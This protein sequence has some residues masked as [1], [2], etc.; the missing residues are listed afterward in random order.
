M[1]FKTK[2]YPHQKEWF[3]KTKDLERFAFWWEM[4][5]VDAETEYLSPEGWVPISQYRGGKVAQ[6]SPSGGL[7]GHV[8]FV[9]PLRY[10]VRPCEEFITL[11]HPRG[12]SQV[13]SPDHRVPY[14]TKH[15]NQLHVT[16]A[17]E[18]AERLNASERSSVRL[19]VRCQRSWSS[20]GLPLTDQELR[21]QVA[22]MA[23]GSFPSHSPHT[24]RCSVRIKKQRKVARL[25][26][27]L[28]GLCCN[29]NERRADGGFYVFSFDAP[30]RLKQFPKEWWTEVTAEQAD[31][32][33]DELVHWDSHLR[34]NGAWTYDSRHESDVDFIQFLAAMSGMVT[35]KRRGNGTWS[36]HRR[37]Q[38]TQWQMATH[39]HVG[40]QPS[41]DGLAYCFTVP[42]S[43]LVLRRS[44]AVF[45]TGNCGKSKVVIDTAHHLFEKGEID[46]VLVIAPAAVAPNWISDEVPTHFYQSVDITTF[47][48]DSKKAG[49]KGVQEHLRHLMASDANLFVAMSYDAIRTTATGGKK[50]I[51]GRE[52]TDWLISRRC[53][54]VLDESARIKTPSA[55][56]TKRCWALGKKAKYVRLLTG[57][58]VA[59]SPFDVYAQL[60]AMEDGVW[61]RMGCRQFAAFKAQ[62]GVWEK[63]FTQTTGGGLREYPELLAYRNLDQLKK[64][65]DQKGSRLLKEDVLDLPAKVY[66]TRRFELSAKQRKFYTTLKEEFIAFLEGED[67]IEGMVAAPL[68][69]TRMLRFQQATSGYTVTDEGKLV[70]LIDEKDNPRLALLSDICE[71]ITHQFLVW[72]KF[73]AD[74]DAIERRLKSDGRSVVVIDGR[75]SQ[76]ERES[77]REAFRNGADVLV[78]NP[79]CAGEGLTLTQAKTV[80]Y[81]NNS[82]KLTDRLQSEDRAHRI[83]QDTSVLYVDIVAQDTIDEAILSALRN[84]LDISRE[85]TGDRIRNWL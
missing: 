22:V 66:A 58:P 25:R 4:G 55:K 67:Q 49:N 31:T 35:L 81:Y 71:D 21:L 23:D 68:M 69:L 78:A 40:K 11:R 3:E 56:R 16:T 6:W 19:P 59:N 43:Y 18:L 33:L 79:A 34:E 24:R 26:T 10:V 48:W 76:D 77:A 47:C 8:T 36:L 52:F 13:L 74:I 54:L 38:L 1:P 73:H 64:V 61:D 12:L 80:I 27:L 42:S 7:S 70:H 85:V 5:C 39:G 75:R 53:L 9:K 65:V 60:R 82:F 20:P 45:V 37:S 30:M 57:T 44:G 50:V 41:V 28:S 15:G 46:T 14:F 84:K 63:R 29:V 32:I 62:F 83:G 2:P 51:K 72:A 17:Q